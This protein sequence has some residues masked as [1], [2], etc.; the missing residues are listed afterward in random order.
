M[1]GTLGMLCLKLGYAGGPGGQSLAVE[2]PP[3]GYAVC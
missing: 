3:E 1:L 2:Q